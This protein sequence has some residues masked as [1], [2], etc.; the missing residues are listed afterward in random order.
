M[1]QISKRLGD[2]IRRIRQEKGMSQ[3]D[4]SR[5]LGMDR[6]YISRIENGLKNPTLANIEK[7]AN[8]MGV[9]VNELF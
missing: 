8:A 9:A 5:A 6:G 2:N 3:G 4:I 7:I 1:T